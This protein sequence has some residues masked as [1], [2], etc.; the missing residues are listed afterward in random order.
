MSQ[1]TKPTVLRGQEGAIYFIPGEQLAQYRVSGDKAAEVEQKL[2]A[3]EDPDVAGFSFEHTLTTSS[4]G[5]DDPSAPT[6]SDA[7]VQL[8]NIL[9]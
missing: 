9:G 4:L 6:P 8:G 7:P 2:Q 3:A 1:Q 5:L